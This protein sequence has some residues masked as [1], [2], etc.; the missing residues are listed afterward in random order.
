MD[1]ARVVL[2]C[3]RAVRSRYFEAALPLLRQR[4]YDVHLVT[5]QPRGPL[6]E[7]VERLGFAASS[8]DAVQGGDY[9]KAA[10]RLR[11][12]LRQQRPALVHAHEPISGAIAG[13]A[14]AGPQLPAVLYHR[15]HIG[16][17]PKLLW[18]S[19][20]ATLAARYVVCVSAATAR[21]AESEDRTRRRKILVAH[22][23]VSA[24]R[25]VLH[26]ETLQLRHELGIAPGQSVVLVLSR[27][28]P[29][30]GIE[31]LL[32]ALP[33][34]LG[35]QE[36]RLVIA[37][38]GPHE[39]ALRTRVRE[40]ALSER[41]SFVGHQEDIAL[42][43]SLAD[44]VALPSYEDPFPLA[45]LEALASGRPLVASRVGGLPEMVEE[46]KSGLLVPPGDPEALA[47]ALTAV[48]SDPTLAASLASGAH[49]RY[50]HAFTMQAMVE[51][52]SAAYVAAGAACR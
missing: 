27:L 8:L 50:N 52:W 4:G 43:L 19:R 7:E 33:N 37:G 49:S 16:P 23:G 38:S 29:V 36:P 13:A 31:V 26:D 5:T 1:S 17:N 34:V 45:A 35:G 32:Q 30:K 11:R 25:R 40:L 51:Q 3:E 24:P 15:H 39:E 28:R 2:L 20:F 44:V 41:V 48:L 14:A 46:G 47:E 10:V 12:L 9:P 22:N 42:W 21:A 18:L 6:H